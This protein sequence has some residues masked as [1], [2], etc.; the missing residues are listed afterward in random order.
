MWRTLSLA[1]A[2]AAAPVGAAEIG[3][4]TFLNAEE[5]IPW[6][7]VGRVNMTE[8]NRV[9]M[10]TG[11]LIR[12][13]V[14]LTAAH[15]VVNL[16]TGK[17][18]P[19]GTVHFLAG[20]HK[21][22]WT[23]HSRARAFVVH[24]DWDG[25]RQNQDPK[26][27]TDLALIRLAKPLDVSAATPFDVVPFDS[28]AD[29]EAF[30]LVGYRRDRAHA[31]TYQ[32]DCQRLKQFQSRFLLLCSAVKGASGSP[33]FA[34]T[35]QGPRIVAVLSAGAQGKPRAQLFTAVAYDAVHEMLGRLE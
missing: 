32:D 6:R 21:G 24:P 20:W 22:K 19:P 16:K 33:I 34:T 29:D 28:H 14:V 25:F 31:L 26:Y 35:A 15:C 10:C 1:L 30:I 2:L 4:D 8:P 13:D 27:A 7:A 12:P 17:L 3:H 11:T 23:G 18:R 9:R 5:S